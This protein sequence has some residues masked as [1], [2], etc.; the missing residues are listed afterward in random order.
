MQETI[1]KATRE[2]A[3]PKWYTNVNAIKMSLSLST[4]PPVSGS[5]RET[6]A[7]AAGLLSLEPLPEEVEAPA[8]AA[9]DSEPQEAEGRT[10]EA[11]RVSRC[12]RR[13]SISTG[14]GPETG[15]PRDLSSARR[16]FTAKRKMRIE[17][18]EAKLD[19]IVCPR[20]DLVTGK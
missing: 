8:S 6:A 15:K 12:G 9:E 17:A 7:V 16:S 1:V 10:E 4:L 19:I 2:S 3:K 14:L 13:R 18:I 20:S 11:N 5:A